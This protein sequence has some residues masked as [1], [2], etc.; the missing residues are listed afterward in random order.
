[1]NAPLAGIGHN[2]GPRLLQPGDEVLWAP[3]EGPQARLITCP[4]FEVM[5]GGA[6]G[7]GKTDGMLGDWLIHSDT[8]GRH[9]NGLMVRRTMEALAETI[10]RAK[11]LFLPLGSKYHAQSKTFRMPTGRGSSFATSTATKTPKP[12]RAI[13]TPASMSKN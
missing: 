11:E 10:E 9:A 12:I 4:V 6:R 7:G 1:M 5:Y 3:Q 8:Y 13:P 2:G